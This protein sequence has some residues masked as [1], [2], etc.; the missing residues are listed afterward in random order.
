M[1]AVTILGLGL[2]MI[3]SS[4][5]GLLGTT[6]RI[7]NQAHA[8][9]LLRCKI[10]EVEVELLKNGYSM[11]DVEDSGEC[12]EDADA[13]NFSCSWKVE[14]VELPQPSAFAESGSSTD[15][16]KDKSKD[17]DSS[18]SKDAKSDEESSSAAPAASISSDFGAFSK[19]QQLGSASGSGLPA[20]GKPE[21][22]M[23]ALSSGGG[24]Q[25]IVS[26]IMSMVYPMLKPM[27]EASIR[28][29]SVTISW[30]EG[31]GEKSMTVV[32]FVTNPT[33]GG[34]LSG[35]QADAMK[36]MMGGPV[37]ATGNSPGAP[38]TPSTGNAA[39]SGGVK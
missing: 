3:L 26:M 35:A 19:F 30:R 1:V 16:D 9:T 31:S 27:L 34:L 22:L 33:Q 32:E 4:Q 18:K 38:S 14:K 28:R 5:A 37:G 6:W 13:D 23:G 36:Q 11:T 2:T 10:S 8:D 12:C 39:T 7:R 21:D 17:S 15:T 25:G 20:G 29:I 24:T